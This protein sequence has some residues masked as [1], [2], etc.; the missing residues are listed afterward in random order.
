MHRI[1]LTALGFALLLSGVPLYSQSNAGVEKAL[2]AKEHAGWQG[3]KDHTSK[4]VEAM[5]PEDVVNIA[6]G[7]VARGRQQVLHEMESSGR[8][9]LF[10]LQLY[11]FVAE[12]RHGADDL[13]RH[14]GCNLFG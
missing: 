12:Q 11:L 3:W 5:T 7:M 10:T 8:Q 14:S 13:H 6:D 2:E 4:P 1:P 9:R